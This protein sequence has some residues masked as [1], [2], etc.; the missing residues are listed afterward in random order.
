MQYNYYYGQPYPQSFYSQVTANDD[1][2]FNMSRQQMLLLVTPEELQKLSGRK[3]RTTVP[4]LGSITA[5]VGPY[6]PNTN[7][8]QLQNIVSV[9]DGMNHGTLGYLPTELGGLQ[10]LDTPG[11][12]G[13]PSP[14][15]TI[16]PDQL[17][18]DVALTKT[19]GSFDYPSPTA[20]NPFRRR[21]YRVYLE[22]TVPQAIAQT[23]Q[24]AL[25][26]CMEVA[27][28][29][30]LTILAPF[31]TPVTVGGLLAAIPGALSA[32]LQAFTTCVATVPQIYPY[33]NR[34]KVDI[35]TSDKVV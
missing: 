31:L 1:S 5:T 21:R 32:A 2:D 6:D 35:K 10:V 17:G 9:A 18:Q 15:P 23:V 12:G 33:L 22:V 30:A 16:P 19:I 25:D 28:A 29:R 13:E 27:K 4:N 20:T 3:I 7:R 24:S 11:T 8:V 26:R 14:Q 34:I